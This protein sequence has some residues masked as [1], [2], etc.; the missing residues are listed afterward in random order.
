LRCFKSASETKKQIERPRRQ[1]GAE[2]DLASSGR[3]EERLSENF[4]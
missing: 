1:A 3:L 2:A 4:A